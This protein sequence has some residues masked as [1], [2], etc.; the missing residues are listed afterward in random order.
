MANAEHLVLVKQGVESW[1]RWREQNNNVNS[2]RRDLQK[3]YVEVL[4]IILL[5]EKGYF[6]SD[7]VALARASLRELYANIKDSLDAGFFDDYTLAHLS[8]CA[9]KIKSVYKAQTVLN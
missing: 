8:E 7:A 6:H 5:N 1:N 4:T 3:S 2:F 9:N